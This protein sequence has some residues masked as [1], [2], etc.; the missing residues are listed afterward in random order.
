MTLAT[1]DLIHPTAV[2]DPDAEI[3]RAVNRS[4]EHVSSMRRRLGLPL[5]RA[6]RSP[7]ATADIVRLHGEGLTD[8]QIAD[9]LGV[10]RVVI[11]KRRNNA[12]LPINKAPAKAGASSS[13]ETT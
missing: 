7:I 4:R 12:G 5:I 8:T 9:R 1:T 10:E 3:A 13:Q 6:P 11:Q 2:I